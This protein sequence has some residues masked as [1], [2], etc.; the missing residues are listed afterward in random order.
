MRLTLFLIGLILIAAKSNAKDTLLLGHTIPEIVFEDEKEERERLFTPQQITSVSAEDVLQS[1]PSNT[2]D[3]LQKNGAVMVQMSQSGGGSPIVRGFEANRILL[4]VDGVRLNNAIFRSGHIQNI[5]STSPYMLNK[6]DVIFGPASVKYGSDALGGV[7]HIHTKSPEARQ[8]TK[9]QFVQKIN[10]ANNGVSSHFDIA[11]SKGKWSYLHALS[12]HHYGNLKM[13]GNRLHGYDDWGR[14]THIT[15]GVEQLN[16]S[17]SQADFMQKIR[18]DANQN[19]SFMLNTQASSSTNIPRFD[20]LND[21]SDKGEG[22]FAVWEYG[23]QKRFMNTLSMH[24]SKEKQLFDEF[25]THFA[26]QQLSESR[27]SQKIG[28]LLFERFEKVWVYSLAT[29]FNKSI[30]HNNLNYGFDVQ[31]NLVHSTANE[32]SPSRY[33]DG[34]SDMSN[35]SIFV[36]YK[37]PIA[38]SSYLSGGIRYSNSILNAD[39]LDTETYNLPFESIQLDNDATTGSLGI[40]HQ[41]QKGWEGSASISSGFRSPNVDDVTKVFAKSGTVTVPNKYLTPEYSSNVEFT[42]SKKWNQGHFISGTAFYTILQD[43]IIKE[44]FSLNGQDSL[45]YDGEYLPIVANQNTQEASIWGGH[46]KA[47]AVLNDFWATT[48][49]FN[50]TFGQDSDGNYMDHIPPV[51][52]KSEL[53]WQKDKHALQGFALYNGWKYIENYSPNGSDNPQE[54]TIDGTPAWWTLNLNYQYRLNEMLLAQV[55]LENILDVHYKTYSSGISAPGRN[56]ILTLQASF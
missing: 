47:H 43:A 10:T 33:A 39:F 36:Q 11:W 23:P 27:Y 50:Y 40:F 26:V 55:G 7:I 56:L 31:H 42:I 38:K 51:Y 4:V 9:R 3:I 18:F 20:K 15:D 22:K 35:F 1:N 29:D 6:M 14:E 24:H 52:G 30:G 28:G 32:G 53:S 46:L 8:A 34:G 17:Y 48:H 19:W 44:V 2:A 54:A 45:W 37:H 13:G 49:S 41:L 12:V 5:I 16:T 21:V 25:N